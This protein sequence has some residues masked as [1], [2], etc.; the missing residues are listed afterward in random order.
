MSDFQTVIETLTDLETENFCENDG[1]ALRA[2]DIHSYLTRICYNRRS[3]MDPLYNQFVIAGVVQ[4]K[5]E[6]EKKVE[7]DFYLGYT[8]LYGTTFVDNYVA[9]GIGGHIALPLL[10]KY[11]DENMTIQQAKKVL[12]D[13]MRVLYYRDCRSINKIIFAKVTR[14]GGV[15]IEAPVS[16]ETNWD[17]REINPVPAHLKVEKDEEKTE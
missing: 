4:S 5:E 9:T 15:E 3:R 13:A 11:Y 8:D 12:E 10:R 14:E 17:M 2:P 6:E 1:I 16:L 7:Q